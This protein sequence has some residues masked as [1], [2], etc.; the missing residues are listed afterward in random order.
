MFD[1]SHELT[2]LCFVPIVEVA[3]AY[4]PVCTTEGCG[5]E[6]YDDTDYCAFCFYNNTEPIAAVEPDFMCNESPPES[7]IAS[8][9]SCH[10]DS[11][12]FDQWVNGELCE[13]E[14]VNI[15]GVQLFS[16]DLNP[17]S[18]WLYI[19]YHPRVRSAIV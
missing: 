18:Q 1:F 9:E 12:E 5:Q 17:Y 11:L 3:I 13:T 4:E 10:S 8:A 19:P 2:L 14:N 6:R 7:P 16:P 15:D